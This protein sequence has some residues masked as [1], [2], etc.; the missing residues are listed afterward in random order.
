MHYLK[1]RIGEGH[2]MKLFLF[3][4]VLFISTL[5]TS[6]A[7]AQ[8]QATATISASITILEPMGI[9]VNKD[10]VFPA[11]ASDQPD[12]TINSDSSNVGTGGAEAPHNAELSTSGQPNSS[13]TV[14]MEEGSDQFMMNGNIP[15]G[16]QIVQNSGS[17]IR[18]LDDSGHDT[19]QIRG[20]II[21]NDQTPVP[22]TPGQYTGDATVL[23]QYL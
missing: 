22:S 21:F 5:L 11:L 13:Y 4:P 20:T 14:T 16:I 23:V 12:I 3:I 17:K 1:V 15:V 9:D 7:F 2:Q 8:M 18:T 19:F 10:M 6:D